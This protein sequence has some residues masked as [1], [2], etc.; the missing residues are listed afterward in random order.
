MKLVKEN[1]KNYDPYFSKQKVDKLIED[2]K[3]FLIDIKGDGSIKWNLPNLSKIS[4]N[5]AED[6]LESLRD[7]RDAL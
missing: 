7:L 4:I 5:K 3:K 2:T 6:F 1:L